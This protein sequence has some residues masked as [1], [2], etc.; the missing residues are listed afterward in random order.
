[1]AASSTESRSQM[2]WNDGTR[3]DELGGYQLLWRLQLGVC[4][5]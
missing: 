4:L 2:V 5:S 1:M 3:A